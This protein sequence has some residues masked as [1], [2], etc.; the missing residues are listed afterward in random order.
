MESFLK[1]IPSNSVNMVI[2]SPPYYGLRSYG[3]DA[4]IWGGDSNCS[5]IWDAEIRKGISGG[6]NSKKVNIKGKENFQIVP[7]TNSSTCSL[8]GAWQGELGSEPLLK[9]YIDNLFLIFDEVKRILTDD[10][11]CWVNLGDSY[12]A[13]RTY[14]VTGTKQVDGS[15]PSVKQPQAKDNGISLKS[16]YGVPDRFKIAM[17]DGGYI[18]RNEIIWH[19]LNQMPSSAKD[20]FTVDF[21]KLYWFTK[22]PKYYFEQQLEESEWAKKDK[23]SETGATV[24]GKTADGQYAVKGSGSYRKDGKRNKRSVWGINTKGY[25]GAHFAVFPEELVETPII[26][27]C[28]KDGIV[29]DIFFG[30]G[31]TG[32]VAKKLGRNYIGIELNKEYIKIAEKRIGEYMHGMGNE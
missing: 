32:L 26:S 30:S 2:T 21:E 14:Q 20:R 5:H 28:P 24:N 18:C 11:S 8:C 3:T 31:T 13:N 19:K 10:G 6:T 12:S 22:N 7:D 1:K 29:L 4:Q 9:M 27:C 17:I 25:K 16:L 23:R 15:Q